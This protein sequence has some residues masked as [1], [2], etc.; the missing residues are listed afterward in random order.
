[1]PHTKQSAKKT[2]VNLASNMPPPRAQQ[3][4]SASYPWPREQEGEP[5]DLNS[6]MLLDFNCEG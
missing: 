6:Q 3:P 4:T 5:I 2:R 1:M